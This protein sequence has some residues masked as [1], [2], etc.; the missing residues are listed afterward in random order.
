MDADIFTMS[1][2]IAN[3]KA[4]QDA[5]IA[6]AANQPGIDL[7]QVLLQIQSA[8]NKAQDKPEGCHLPEPE[9]CDVATEELEN[10]YILEVANGY[11]GNSVN[12]V[13]NGAFKFSLRKADR[14]PL[15]T[16]NCPKFKGIDCMIFQF[17]TLIDFS[18]DFGCQASFTTRITNPE[19]VVL[20]VGEGASKLDLCKSMI[21]VHELETFGQIDNH[22][23]HEMTHLEV[24]VQNILLKIKAAVKAEPFKS[25]AEVYEELFPQELDKLDGS[26]RSLIVHMFPTKTS[27][28]RSLYRWRNSLMPKVPITQADF[29]PKRVVSD[30][31]ICEMEVRGP[32]NTVVLLSER[33]LLESFRKSPNR[34]ID[35]TFSTTPF[36]GTIGWAQYLALLHQ[37]NGVWL[38]TAY[39][40]LPDKT[41]ESYV[42]GLNLLRKAAIPPGWKVVEGLPNHIVKDN[43]DASYLSSI[44]VPIDD[45]SS[46][47]LDGPTVSHDT[48]IMSVVP[49][50]A[51]I[52]FVKAKWK[53]DW[54]LG[55]TL[56]I[57]IVFQGDKM[58]LCVF[59][60]NQIVI[61]MVQTDGLIT[62]YRTP[63]PFQVFIVMVR[64]LSYFKFERQT[65]AMVV[66][67]NY[68]DANL[69]ENPRLAECATN[70]IEWW[71]S[72]RLNTPHYSPEEFL[73]YGIGVNEDPTNNMAEGNNLR[74]TVRIGKNPNPYK[75][76]LKIESELRCS[77]LRLEQVEGSVLAATR[78]S[79]AIRLAK[80]REKLLYRVELTEPDHEGVTPLDL[81]KCMKVS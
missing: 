64:A 72:E 12:L 3:L 16:W 41:K 29:D 27:L 61:R 66:L 46:S 37:C 52:F 80:V 32:N 38:S 1:D 78:S 15:V 43:T 31:I 9:Q 53:K 17:M 20:S 13:V 4:V 44:H 54:E 69:L 55:M 49:A 74:N 71:E 48:N 70:L 75:F 36:C 79:E 40:L 14:F 8:M 42:N 73:K 56:A 57:R 21:A 6:A 22:R 67:R 30:K 11:R 65:E 24:V 18:A 19:A 68:R 28:N 60:N 5:A 50:D 2:L 81:E 51:E 63:G 25:P 59:H 62:M 47:L 39:V 33:S 35:G 23:N 58:D 45:T 10:N 7:S 34:S 76:A 26:T 77:A